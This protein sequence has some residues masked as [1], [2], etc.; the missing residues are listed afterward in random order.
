MIDGRLSLLVA[1]CL[2]AAACSA[3]VGVKRVSPERAHRLLT[4]NVLSTGELSGPTEI[5]LRQ[6]DLT[7]QFKDDPV[8]A[9]AEL[10]ELMVDDG[11][12]EDELYALAELSFFD[13]QAENEKPR[14]L[15]AA[16]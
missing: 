9:L 11:A 3:P 12:G 4:S 8:A 16:L 2:L 15:A 10:H 13:A 7:R 6:H 5:L 1:C 14:L